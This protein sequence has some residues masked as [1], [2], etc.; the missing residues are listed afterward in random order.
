MSIIFKDVH[1]YFGS[2]KVLTGVNMSVEPGE[3]LF[4]IGT[5]GVGKSVTIKH[6]IGLLKPTSGEVYVDGIR[7]DLVGEKELFSIRRKVA[8]VFQASALFDSL[9]LLENV[10]LPI[11]KHLKLKDSEVRKKATALL[12]EVGMLKHADLYPSEIGDGMRKRVAIARALSLDP[13]YVLFDEPTTG[14][15]PV[16]ARRVD[17]L[18]SQL[19]SERNAGCI[20]VSHDLVSIF[21]TATKIAMV[22]KGIIY[23]EGPIE[24]FHASPDPVI[25]QFL[26]GSSNGP[27]E[28]PGF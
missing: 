22:Y 5:S 12:D 15:D 3:K 4:V 17:S 1:R 28:T 13:A 20:I 26:S 9:S 7:V 11:R 21:S 25:R 27:M 24:E 16:S 2:K 18:I 10:M 8:M 14:L 23:K 6:I 19:A